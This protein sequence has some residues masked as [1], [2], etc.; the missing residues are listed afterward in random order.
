MPLSVWVS[1]C[2]WLG[3]RGG[4]GGRMQSSFVWL[5]LFDFEKGNSVGPSD[6]DQVRRRRRR[7]RR[8][9]LFKKGRKNL[10]RNE[11]KRIRIGLGGTGVEKQ[12]RPDVDKEIKRNVERRTEPSMNSSFPPFCVE[13]THFFA[14]L[15]HVSVRVRVSEIYEKL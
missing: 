8:R 3:K 11:H 14:L 1:I 2:V 9:S 13:R 6:V 7:R 5:L 4:G 15:L 12:R 10:W